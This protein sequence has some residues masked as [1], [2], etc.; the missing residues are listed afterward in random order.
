MS[1]V[2]IST[3]YTYLA[4]METN[5]AELS[6][7]DTH[8]LSPRPTIQ[9]PLPTSLPSVSRVSLKNFKHHPNKR[10]YSYTDYIDLGPAGTR[11]DFLSH[12]PP[13]IAVYIL[14]F[15][16]PQYLCRVVQVSRVWRY[17][18]QYGSLRTRRLRYIQRKR[19]KYLRSKE[20]IVP[21]QRHTTN[22]TPRTLTRNS[23]SHNTN[24]PLASI[25]SS[26]QRHTAQR[27]HTPQSDD[28][29]DG[30]TPVRLSLFQQ[31]SLYGSRRQQRVGSPILQTPDN[32]GHGVTDDD[33]THVYLVRRCLFPHDQS[34]SN[35]HQKQQ[36]H[37][38]C[39]TLVD[40]DSSTVR[41]CDL[42]LEKSASKRRL[43]RL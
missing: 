32:D 31:R 4:Y 38:R 40:H 42:T 39:H 30:E 14:R 15:L 17:L 16:H 3:A 7:D 21:G 6:L 26:R 18:A 41:D 24:S 33:S 29:R 36:Q 12:L 19:D 35:A 23:L 5:L 11:L 27:I 25:Q 37:Q 13:E 22:R 20:N 9:R 10:L 34:L 8:S 43:K 28:V 1:G 2:S